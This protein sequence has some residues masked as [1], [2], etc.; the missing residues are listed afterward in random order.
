[1]DSKCWLL[2]KQALDVDKTDSPQ[3]SQQ[4]EWCS[5]HVSACLAA[6]VGRSVM[7]LL[8]VSPCMDLERPTCW[9]SKGWMSRPAD[10]DVSRG[11]AV[12]KLCSIGWLVSPIA[13]GSK[14]HLEASH[15]NK[16]AADLPWSTTKEG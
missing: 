12:C 5:N 1:M 6:C 13:V 10:G 7:T 15:G 11:M 8:F 16:G 9:S 3:A 14:L 2:G 4:A